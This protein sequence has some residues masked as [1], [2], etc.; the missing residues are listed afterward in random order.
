M[1]G[2]IP[3]VTTLTV[4]TGLMHGLIPIVTTLTVYT[5]LTHGHIPIAV[6]YSRRKNNNHSILNILLI[7][8]P[9]D[10]I[11]ETIRARSNLFE[12]HRQEIP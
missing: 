12:K 11:T 9:F 10:P 4:Y 8:A 5:G 1:H 3:I 7:I 2:H 6:N